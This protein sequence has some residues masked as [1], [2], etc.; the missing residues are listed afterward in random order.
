MSTAL[1]KQRE[2]PGS[3]Y[4]SRG[5]TM[6]AVQAF[7]GIVGAKKSVSECPWLQLLPKVVSGLP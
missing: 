6:R 5:T 3:G 1:E 7:T 2:A 4:Q